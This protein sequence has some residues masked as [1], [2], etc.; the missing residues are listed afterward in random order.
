MPDAMGAY[1][2]RGLDDDLR[3]VP[4]HR[5][6]DGELVP[7]GTDGDP[8]EGPIVAVLPATGAVPEQF[9]RDDGTAVFPLDPDS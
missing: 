4:T 5:D 1:K 7:L 9:R 8:G 3:A 2:I 6:V